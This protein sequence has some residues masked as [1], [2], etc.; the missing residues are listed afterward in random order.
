MRP[1]FA[2]FSLILVATAQ[3]AYADDTTPDLTPAANR[4]PSNNAVPDETP[5]LADRPPLDDGKPWIFG[6]Q[7]TISKEKTWEE[8]TALEGYLTAALK[9][10]VKAQLFSSYDELSDALSGGKVDI[11][12]INPFPFVHATFAQPDIRAV[13]KV[14]RNGATTYRSAIFVRKSS[15]AQSLADLKGAKPAWVDKDSSA[16]YLY[17][18]AMFM[19]A[20]VPSF[21]NEH[22]YGTHQAA[23]QAVVSGEAD[24]GATFQNES[25]KPSPDGCVNSLGPGPG[26]QLRALIAS[27]P[28]PNEVIAVRSGFNQDVADAMG[29][30]FGQMSE[31]DAGRA[32][33]KQVFEAEGF[34]APLDSDFDSVRNVAAMV[35]GE[36]PLAQAK[37]APTPAPASKTKKKKQH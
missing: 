15:T 28:I 3:T 2:L 6:V 25:D 36:K 8:A 16:G 37:A 24:F 23:C 7:K 1:S 19:K 32:V 22:F 14:L 26:S 5:A 30:V 33:L 18:R 4:A 13:A 29:V 10:K 11:A 20:G 35:R 21:P 31:T 27:G 9:H 17:P 34:G 12:W